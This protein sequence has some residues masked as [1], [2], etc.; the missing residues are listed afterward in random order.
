MKTNKTNWR[1]ALRPLLFGLVAGIALFIALHQS[2]KERVNSTRPKGAIVQPSGNSAASAPEIVDSNKEIRRIAALTK[3]MQRARDI[4]LSLNAPMEFHGRV[5]DQYGKPV[6][7]VSA[8]LTYIYYSA[9]VLAAYEPHKGVEGRVTDENGEF[10]F[11]GK[12][13]VTLTVNLEP[14]KGLRFG[15]DGYWSHSFQSDKQSGVT[16]QPTSR[17]KPYIFRAYRLGQPAELG[18]GSLH[19]LLEPD[20]QIYSLSLDKK[21]ITPGSGGD[22]QITVWQM[23]D[24]VDKK[25]SAWGVELKGHGLVLQETDDPFLYWAPSEGY[26][27]TWSFSWSSEDKKYNANRTFSFWIKR[28]D[29]YGSLRVEFGAFFREK[30]MVEPLYALNKKPGDPNLQPVLPDWPPKDSPAKK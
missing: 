29:Y 19:Q 30:L 7:G 20:R 8:K 2:S 4:G 1:R 13:G 24:P 10:S 12:E 25:S 21:T 14:R 16:V 9:V 22:I 3:T 18:T 28:G 5:V 17:D 15:K 6:S 26:G 11:T 23:R 27:P